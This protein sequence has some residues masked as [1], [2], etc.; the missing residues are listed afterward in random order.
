[1]KNGGSSLMSVICSITRWLSVSEEKNS[2]K[3]TTN[4][5]IYIKMLNF[6]L[7]YAKFV[8]NLTKSKIII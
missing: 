6:F 5:K 2:I 3:T 7:L 8:H 4:N 1:M